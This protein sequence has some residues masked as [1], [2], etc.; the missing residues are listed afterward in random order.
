MNYV[1]AFNITGVAAF[2]LLVAACGQED[3]Y[4]VSPSATNKV[5][6]PQSMTNDN[7]DGHDMAEMKGADTDHGAGKVIEVD[8]EG[9]RIKLDHDELTNIGM[10]A[11]TMFFGIAGDVNLAA[12]ET[13]DDVRFMVKKGRDGS[14][15]IM[16]MCN[17]AVD[18]EDCLAA[19][20]D[21]NE[22]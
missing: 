18:G 22:R 10:N 15:R 2:S 4:A 13:G 16:T 5:E 17:A 1:N 11:M 12:F 3:E 6:E 7:H 21:H 9:R 14:Y 8:A 19:M 20:M